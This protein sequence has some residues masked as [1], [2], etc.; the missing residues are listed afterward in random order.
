VDATGVCLRC[1]G[2]QI[3]SQTMADRPD[4]TPPLP[5]GE[6]AAGPNRIGPYGILNELGRGGM[7]VVYL[8]QHSQLG[9]IV[10]LKVIP[11]GGGAT[12]DLEMRFLR[13]ARTMARLSHPHI[14]T[15]HDA[16][17]DRGHAYFAMDYF[18]EGDLAR[19]LRAQPFA[20][21]EA[22]AVMRSVA[23]AIACSHA[24]GVLHRDLKPSNILLAGGEPHVAD[25][26]LASELDSGGGLTARTAILGT[27]HYL[28]P[29]ALSRG[30][31]A[32][33][34]PSDLYSL[35]VILHEM[36]TGR[37]PFAGASPAE[38]PG[39]LARREAPDLRL[40]APQVPRDLATICAKCLEFDPA[41]RYATATALAGD[42]DCFL[43]GKPI[44][45]RPV[46]A[47]SQL[48]RWA[49]RRPALAATWL[50]SLALAVASLTAA[51][52]INRERLRADG[53]AVTSAA[54]ADFLGKDVLGQA[55]AAE[56]PDRD[57]K[58][59]TAL[60]R[61]AERIPARFSQAPL[62]EAAVRFTVGT[63]Y[64]SLGEYSQAERQ[65]QRTMALRRLHLGA[66]D[67]ESLRAAI[68]LAATLNGLGR[69][70]EAAPLI[71][72]T[73]ADLIRTVGP[74]HPYAIS[75][76]ETETLVERGLGQIAR[77]E[78]L[79]RET[80]ALARRALGPDHE[81]TCSALVNHA[82]LL[83][84]QGKLD[85][86]IGL[87]REVVGTSVRT[88]GRNHPETL[89]RRVSLATLEGE[90]G[91]AKEAEAVLRQLH[92][93]LRRQLGPDHPETLRA[94]ANR[95]GALSKLK[96]YPEAEATFAEL[97]AAR[98]RAAGD[99]H[100]STLAA[101]KL[102]AI[103]HGRNGHLDEAISLMRE[104]AGTSARTLGPAHLTTLNYLRNLAAMLQS[105][106]RFD[107]ALAPAE[108]AYTT[109]LREFGAEAAN[110]L[111]DAE[112]FAQALNFVGRHGEAEPI[113]RHVAGSLMRTQPDHWRSHYVR[114][115]L[116]RTLARDGRPAEA[117]PLLRESYAALLARQSALPA[118]RRD[119]AGVFAGQLALVYAALGRPADAA[120]W[121][122]KGVA[123]AAPAPAALAV[124]EP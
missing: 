75:A 98:R 78:A 94:L 19:R 66:K 95:G 119:A 96:Q 106:R 7:G 100:P 64:Y 14:V 83:A 118:S 113:L 70:S 97:V 30:S 88:L 61:A 90:Q 28:A 92:D 4:S 6:N 85:E 48:Y 11:S 93:T 87:L 59:R 109:S 47:A 50:L 69:S 17:R 120:A 49:R 121:Q 57:L 82:T 99:E 117:E 72:A 21:R 36:L 81:L 43:A 13:E 23:E 18:E 1:A 73:T 63:I 2:E 107:E 27:P 111:A 35:G 62:A 58:L 15:V 25:F 60:D 80:L 37:T 76:M 32:Q 42:L 38:L 104:L 123:E 10:A 91:R 5:S 44:R 124:P 29:E 56:E 53:E 9:R 89:G 31:A 114:G 8:A 122:A 110:T 71:R 108:A 79:A 54:L 101:I 52:L 33:G 12:S 105:A 45:A 51:V 24:A 102:L 41:R 77:A 84:A 26:G 34:V 112:V 20:P 115:L 116:G 55:S 40:L 3:F 46:S 65:F 74:D 103:A 16:G 86:A 67:P 39:L 68:E 22:A